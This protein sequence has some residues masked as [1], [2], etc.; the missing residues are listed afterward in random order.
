MPLHPSPSKGT[1]NI[2]DSNADVTKSKELLIHFKG[3]VGGD[4]NGPQYFLG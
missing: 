2:V 1:N 4:K 3:T